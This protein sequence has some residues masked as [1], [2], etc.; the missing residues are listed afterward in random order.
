MNAKMQV[1]IM[2]FLAG[3]LFLIATGI[4]HSFGGIGNDAM[5]LSTIFCVYWMLS[6]ANVLVSDQ[7]A[8]G[9]E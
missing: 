9:G 3:A 4:Q 6:S 7:P 5:W 8:G 2:H 1:A